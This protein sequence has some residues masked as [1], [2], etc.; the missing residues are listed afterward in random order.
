MSADDPTPVTEP[1]GIAN[2]PSIA[3]GLPSVQ[4][5]A[6][7]PAVVI[8][9]VLATIAF[10][11]LGLGWVA[12]VAYAPLFWAVVR[13][14]RPRGAFGLAYLFGILHFGGL[15]PWI[16]A[17]V[18]AW[19]GSAFGWA[20]WVV[21]ALIQGL[22][23]GLFGYLAW[24][25]KRGSK[26]D[27]RLVLTASAWVVVEWLRGQGGLSMPWGL[28][29]YTQYRSLAIIQIA[30]LTGVY[31]VS[32]LVALAGAAAANAFSRVQAPGISPQAR[33]SV[34]RL[35]GY[36][37]DVGVLVLPCLFYAGALTYG[38]LNVG[39]PWQGR[40]VLVAV[41]QPNFPSTGAP[42]PENEALSRLA[43]AAQRLAETAPS[44]T[45][46]P[47]SAAPADAV[48]DRDVNAVFTHFAKLTSGYHLTGTAYVDDMGNERN[49]AVLFDRSLGLVSRYDKERLVPFGEWIP[50]RSV[51][52]PLIA[53][54]RRPDEDLVPGR[55]Q[56]PLEAGDMRLGVLI[57]Y[58]SIF[59]AMTRDR[60]REGA[61]LLVSITNDGW[62][63]E[64]ASLEQHYAMSVFRAVEARRC[65]CA[66]GLTGTTALISPNGAGGVAAPYEPA[67]VSDLVYLR[68]G[69]TPYARW[70][71][72]LVALA[73]LLVLP[74][75]R[76]GASAS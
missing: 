11:P 22:W 17:T 76:R 70:G 55:N 38:L 66:A 26:G 28:A 47:E 23:F 61:D 8:S 32:F 34:I 51:L 31:G 49:S 35:G 57:C 40:P 62:A 9:A 24:F 75:L 21:L 27:G 10:P 39:L 53:A 44:L 71:D 19:S 67:I 43:A 33:R 25:V 74:A 15:T 50:A 59:P 18:A 29:G 12:W 46:W 36:A 42:L 5:R 73:V 54:I 7:W 52:A 41:V 68:T 3:D 4:R 16:G 14:G 56:K 58:E 64:S 37:A 30:D 63:G 60:V 2:K 6:L 72:W 20:A 45:V 69:L 65:M 48:N 13:A 1:I